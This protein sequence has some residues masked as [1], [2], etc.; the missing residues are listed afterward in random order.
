MGFV[1]VAVLG[2]VVF[3]IT[4]WR[5]KDFLRLIHFGSELRSAPRQLNTDDATLLSYI[6]L[7]GYMGAAM[8]GLF[9]VVGTLALVLD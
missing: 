7:L 4:G 6:R 5:A 8:F 2:F 3:G 1:L 9:V